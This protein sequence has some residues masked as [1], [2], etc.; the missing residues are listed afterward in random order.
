[1]EKLQDLMCI[2]L[3]KTIKQILTQ[4]MAIPKGGKKNLTQFPVLFSQR[5]IY[6]K[7]NK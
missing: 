4:N 7:P 2:H 1:M 6:N 5:K 3:R